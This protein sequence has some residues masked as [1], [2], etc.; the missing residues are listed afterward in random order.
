LLRK[1]FYERRRNVARTCHAFGISRQ[2]FN[3]G[4]R[5]YDPHELTPSA[6]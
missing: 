4:Q 6:V 1:D 5:R 2:T 3:H